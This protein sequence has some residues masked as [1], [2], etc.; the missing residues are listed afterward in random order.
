MMLNREGQLMN[1]E[2]LE[3]LALAVRSYSKHT[4]E[5]MSL[6]VRSTGHQY[7]I[8]GSDLQALYPTKEG[9][10]DHQVNAKKF[11]KKV[12]E[13]AWAY[14]SCQYP[15]VISVMDGVTS[16]AG[17]AVGLNS[18]F[19]C[20]T[21]NTVI[22]LTE[23]SVGFLPHAGSTYHYPRLPG[24]VGT[25]LALTGEPI[26][27]LDVFFAGLASHYAPE[28]CYDQL[29]DELEQAEYKGIQAVSDHVADAL[30]VNETITK[31]MRQTYSL[32][33][34]TNA[35]NRCFARDTVEEILAALDSEGTTWSQ[36]TAASIRA[37]SP[38][39]LKVTLRM[40]QSA[41][42][43]SF[44]ECLRMEHHAMRA[45]MDTPDY[46]AGIDSV[47]DPEVAKPAWSPEKLE[48]INE[49]EVDRF[50]KISQNI[51]EKDDLRVGILLEDSD[52]GQIPDYSHP[53]LDRPYLKDG[54]VPVDP[55][56]EWELTEEEEA[57][58]AAEYDEAD[59][60]EM[61]DAPEDD[62]ESG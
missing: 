40:L 1:E 29:L 60:D 55:S 54:H 39:A 35:I 22:A 16:G 31:D 13:L 34:V 25:Y 47:I 19:A 38:I 46:A 49:S 53:N 59:K 36:Q 30:Q 56:E 4:K 33:P 26:S 3:Y 8:P 21:Q 11:F 51:S 43:L 37:C 48:D 17:L 32:G 62:K 6:V 45:I 41:K 14:N 20:A 27:G 12:Q 57:A 42:T 24:H 10:E 44:E 52:G 28:H 61:E 15:P 7:F 58:M 23:P 18:K 5:L 50:F 2:M 9:F